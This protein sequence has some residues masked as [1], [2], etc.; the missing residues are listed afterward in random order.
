VISVMIVSGMA[1][2]WV[3]EVL[4]DDE[5]LFGFVPRIAHRWRWTRKLLTCAWCSGAWF[6]GAMSL[7]LYHPSPAAALITA[8]ASA[9][10]CGVIG[11][12]L[13]GE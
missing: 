11:S 3:W 12:Y 1:G 9:S 6:S 8:L 2:L 13:Q 7:T 5:G 10:V 4:N